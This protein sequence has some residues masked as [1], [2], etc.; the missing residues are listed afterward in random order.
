MDVGEW[1]DAQQ[2]QTLSRQRST[3]D[4]AKLV[5]T[6]AAAAASALVGPSLQADRWR[7]ANVTAAVALGACVLLAVATVLAD[8]LR[9]AD[10]T[11]VAGMISA[12]GGPLTPAQTLNLLRWAERTAIRANERFLRRVRGLAAVQVAAALVSLGAA[13]YALLYPAAQLVPL[14]T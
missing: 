6:F 8:R 11:A 1:L 9:G 5:V 4:I 13:M 3:A 10:V 7:P 2:A 14:C 12:Q